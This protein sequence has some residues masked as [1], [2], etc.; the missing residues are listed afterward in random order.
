MSHAL[1]P[2][3]DWPEEHARTDAFWARVRRGTLARLGQKAVLPVELTR[4][5][6]AEVPALWRDP[7]CVFAQTCWGPLRL[8]LLA[9][10]RVLAQPD[11]SAYAGG[12]GLYY[13]SAL[14]ARPETARALGVLAP[15]PPPATSAATLPPDLLANR[16]L[17][18]NEASSLSGFLTLAADLGG[19]PRDQSACVETG[20]HRAS[21]RAVAEGRAE[22][23]AIDCRSWHMAVQHESCATALR[24]VGWSREQPGLPYVTSRTS[25]AALVRALQETL[26]ETGCLPAL[27]GDET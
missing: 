3:Y 17:A 15:A 14:V 12:R 1:L 4:V 25:P 11:Y 13:R 24:V 18:F 2:M 10:L 23:A 8:G 21:I 9:A 27:E 26:I 19:D 6:W 20:S 7:G 5:P 16:R 22:I